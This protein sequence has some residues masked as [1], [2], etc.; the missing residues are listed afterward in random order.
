MEIELNILLLLGGLLSGLIVGCAMQKSNFCMAAAVSNFVLM[1]DYR[2]LHAYLV[3]LIVAIAGTQLLNYSGIISLNGS[4]YRTPYF[5]W[6][7]AVAGGVLFG[8]GAILAGGCIGKTIVRVGEG[9]L[10]ALIVILSSGIVGASTMYGELEPFRLWLRELTVTTLPS[11]DNTIGYFTN[12]PTIIIAVVIS[13]LCIINMSTTGKNTRSPLLLSTGA[14]IGLS[15]VFSWWVTGYLS[16][17]IFSIHRPL[18]ITYAG[19]LTNLSEL[20]SSGN[21]S[22]TAAQFGLALIL[23]TLMGSNFHAV[24]SQNFRWTL[25]ETHHIIH[26]IIGGAMM[27][28]GAV[29]AGGCNFGQ[30]LSGLSTL[31]MLSLIAIISIIFGMKLGIIY[32]LYSEEIKT[33]KKKNHSVFNKI[34]HVSKSN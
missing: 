32:L 25:P 27:G 19:P 3:A 18:S 34:F 13:T 6:F 4:S 1:K 29:L 17:D 20:I 2:Q 10:G 8:V 23:G 15:V 24:I 22:G 12:S 21:H 26:L 9:N 33:N 28:F 30:G 14:I 11:N 16:Q 5:D 7:G 31:S